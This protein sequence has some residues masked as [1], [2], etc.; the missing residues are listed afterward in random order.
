MDRPAPFKDAR[1]AAHA[2]DGVRWF[3]SAHSESGR[4]PAPGIP[5]V[6]RLSTLLAVLAVVLAGCG[7]TK[8]SAATGRADIVPADAR[9]FV[10]LDTDLVSSQ[11]QTIDELASLFPDKEKL[12]RSMK[13]D[14]LEDEDV[15]WDKD[16]RPALGEE[17]A[18]V[19]LDFENDA[20]NAVGL[21]QPKDEDAFKR[22]AAK[23]DEELVS[24]KVGD[25]Y[26]FS[27]KPAKIE[28]FR[29]ASE[30]A[31]KFLADDSTFKGAMDSFPDD[32]LV[33]AFVDGP[34]LHEAIIRAGGAESRKTLNGSD[35]SIGSSP[36]SASDQ[37][38]RFDTTAHGRAGPGLKGAAPNPFTP[39]LTREVPSD[40]LLYFTFRGSERDA[41][42]D[43]Y[44]RSLRPG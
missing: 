25:W 34:P 2:P 13:R 12:I 33:R 24:E 19:W 26:V 44:Q 23:A 40:A 36:S 42:R 35:A 32:S 41:H 6:Q 29:K 21:I 38:V 5:A 9:A 20:E 27:D 8:E 28:Q 11:W 4:R 43:R 30:A 16:V 10:F 37:G 31:D 15:D 18:V 3:A 39:S 17:L 22:L 14:L 7:G 1:P